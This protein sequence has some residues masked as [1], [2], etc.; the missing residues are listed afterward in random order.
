[1]IIQLFIKSKII[2]N[3]TI[4]AELDERI[5]DIKKRI[6]EKTGFPSVNQKLIYNNIIMEDHIILNNYNMMNESDIILVCNPID[7]IE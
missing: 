1:M 7:E 4:Y 5:I 2:K 3:I 6:E